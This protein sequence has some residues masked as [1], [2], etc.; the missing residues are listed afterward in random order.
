M[1]DLEPASESELEEGEITPPARPNT[2]VEAQPTA[3]LDTDDQPPCPPEP[4]EAQPSPSGVECPAPENVDNSL[5]DLSFE[6]KE[7]ITP[8][9]EFVCVEKAQILL[10]PAHTRK[11]YTR[12]RR[13]M[14]LHIPFVEVPHVVEDAPPASPD[15]DAILPQTPDKQ[16]NTPLTDEEVFQAPNPSE[17]RPKKQRKTKDKR[18]A[19]MHTGPRRTRVATPVPYAKL[20]ETET[21]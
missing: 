15:E 8:T 5:I 10:Q 19:L 11:H 1:P 20:E 3:N 14:H 9:G 16:E 12:H 7:P 6:I 13:P 2:P 18:V 17:K 4:E 21:E